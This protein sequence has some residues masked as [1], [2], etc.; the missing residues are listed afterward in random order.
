MAAV[1]KLGGSTAGSEAM[2]VWI[3][4]LA[5][6]ALPLV[7]VPGGG[8]FADA[9]REAQGHMGFSDEAA[10]RMAVLAMEQFA[11]VILDHDHRFVPAQRRSDMERAWSDA[12]VPVWLPRQLVLSDPG[13]PMSWD[14]TSDTL[15][16]WLAGEIDAEA[17]LLI[18]QSSRFTMD[19][20]IA[21]LVAGGIVDPCFGT[22]LPSG[23]DC[24]LAGP[25]HA[26]NAHQ[27]LAKGKLP[28]VQ[29]RAGRPLVKAG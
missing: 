18:K 14:V 16:A 17:L 15:A 27:L 5:A 20:D 7:V 22:M 11:Q 12:A 6:S 2:K 4:A 10:H 26:A 3:G 13:I 28:G 8:P 25:A 1:V 19:D 9:V 21:G 23:V 29:I 24:Y